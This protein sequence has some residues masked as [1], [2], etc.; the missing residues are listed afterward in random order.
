MTPERK[1][2]IED[3]FHS[4]LEREPSARAALLDAACDGDAELRHEVES[5]LGHYQQASDFIEEPVAEAAT[6]LFA[7]KQTRSLAGQRIGHYKI[8]NLLGAGGMGE[9][10]LAEDASLG[11]RVAVKLLPAHFTTDHER[12]RRFQREARAVSA[13]NHPN[14]LTIYEIGQSDSTHFIATEFID[15]VT[16]REHMTSARLQI[17]EAL[18]VAIQVASALAAAHEE[19]IVHRDIKP[20]NIMLRRRDR[21][22]KVLDFGLAKLTGM[23]IADFGMRNEEAETLVQSPQSNPQS[24]APGVVMGTVAYMSPEQ[25]RGLPVDGRTDVWSLGVVLYE[26][27][28]GHAP[29]KGE[30]MSDVLVSILD[31]QPPPLADYLPEVLPRLQQIVERALRKDRGERYQTAKELLTDLRRLKQQLEFEAEMEPSS[32]PEMSSGKA[33]IESGKESA[34]ITGVVGVARS[35]SSVEYI[36]GEIRSHKRGA[37]LALMFLVI[38]TA[39]IAFGIYKF[40]GQIKPAPA[41]PLQTMKITR[42]TATGKA[43]DA[44]IS[45]DGK[46]VVYVEE[47]AKRQSLWVRQVAT[48]SS[49]Q[50]VPPAEVLYFGLTFS[51]DSNYVYYVMVRKAES[52]WVLYQIPSLGGASRK[53]IER[54]DS[55]VAFSPDG[56]R[57]AFVRLS[58]NKGS[59]ALMVANADGTGEQTLTTRKSPDSF[60]S[61]GV[62]RIAWSPDGKVIA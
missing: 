1:Q 59:T 8:L 52:T 57:F 10:Y 50:I 51:N 24:T 44:A 21:I 47:D 11:R 39:G 58:S 9:V 30:T 6:H 36:V 38:V 7:D 28:A 5:L 60:F 48:G 42:L 33:T 12:V 18:D 55:A 53:L 41:A 61:E 4:A 40:A 31:K 37:I 34:T 14:I 49:V 15:G 62:V 27:V 56:K 25:A 43:K 45:P 2:H 26:M 35:T 23:R 3:L 17:T 32:P 16:L 22:V 46:Y 19:G 13:L 54:L 20:E 29:F